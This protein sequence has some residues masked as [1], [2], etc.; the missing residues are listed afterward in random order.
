M[1]IKKGKIGYTTGVFD[2]FHVGHLNILR[3]AKENCDYLIVGVS[4]DELVESYKNKTPII[5]FEHRK[6]IVESIKYIDEVVI[7]SHR[8]KMKSFHEIG[9]DIMFVGSDWKGTELFNV[10]E[11]ELKKYNAI[12]HFFQYT[13]GISST[14]LKKIL[15]ADSKK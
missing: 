1:S 15:A 10:L 2:M 3:Q 6:E 5:P 8:D 12:I 11:K 14:R 7:Q 9:F 4:S 13:D